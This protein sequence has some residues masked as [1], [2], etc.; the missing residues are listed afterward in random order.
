MLGVECRKKITPAEETMDVMMDLL[1]VASETTGVCAGA[2][3]AGAAG[4]GGAPQ[5]G[6]KTGALTLGTK[7]A[8][9]TLRD[10]IFDV[11]SLAESAWFSQLS[12]TWP[13][14]P[15]IVS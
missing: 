6:T 9:L 8:A 13:P 10:D 4:G 15:D 2:A 11:T 3:A 7:E 5:E 1:F 12:A 14:S